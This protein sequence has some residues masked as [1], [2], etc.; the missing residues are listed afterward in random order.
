MKNVLIPGFAVKTFLFDNLTNFKKKFIIVELK[1]Y[2]YDETSA[3]LKRLVEENGRINLSGWSLGTLYALKWT[4]ENPHSIEKLFLTGATSLF[5][6][7]DDYKNGI[8]PSVVER[9]IRLIK[10]GKKKLVLNDF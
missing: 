1:N 4:L 2:T 8:L 9:M 6:E 7:K 10:S 5:V 3:L